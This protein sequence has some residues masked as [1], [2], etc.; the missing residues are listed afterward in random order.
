MNIRKVNANDRNLLKTILCDVKVFS[1]EEIDSALELIEEYFENGPG[2]Y[3]FYVETDRNEKVRGFVCFGKA[4]LS[5]NVY[6]IYWMVVHPDFQGQNVGTNLMNFAEKHIRE[7]GGSMIL[8]ET[9]S[10][11]KYKKAISFYR[12]RGYS[13]IAR[14]PGFYSKGDDK[15]ILAK[16]L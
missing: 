13:Q 5:E 7:N 14:I 1:D 3:Y 6:D 2:E 8:I 12:H 4:A 9:S 15:L 11:P 16:K 10:T